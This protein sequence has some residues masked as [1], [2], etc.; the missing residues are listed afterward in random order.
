MELNKLNGF[1]QSGAL[2]NNFVNK[3]IRN[4]EKQILNTISIFWCIN[5]Q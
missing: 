2:S 3:E 4:Y 5:N 1:E